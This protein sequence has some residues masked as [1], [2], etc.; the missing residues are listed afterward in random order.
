MGARV[1]EGGVG[2]RE[3]VRAGRVWRVGLVCL[4]AIVG[5]EEYLDIRGHW[6]GTVDALMR[7]FVRD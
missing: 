6:H 4:D 7:K 3:E 1:G 5:E 2:G